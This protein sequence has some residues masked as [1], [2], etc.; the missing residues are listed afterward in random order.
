MVLTTAYNSENYR[1]LRLYIVWYSKEHKRTQRFGNWTCFR[2][3]VR[4]GDIYYAGSIRNSKPQSLD[5]L[6]PYN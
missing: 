3:H 6:C 4:S 5:N 1:V 2:P